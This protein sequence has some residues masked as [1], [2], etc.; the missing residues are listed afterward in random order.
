MLANLRVLKNS[1]VFT[2]LGG[3][4]AGGLTYALILIALSVP[5]AR[6]LLHFVQ[7]RVR[8]T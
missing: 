6:G 5:E 8:R 4:T 2:L 3:I 7:G 1:E